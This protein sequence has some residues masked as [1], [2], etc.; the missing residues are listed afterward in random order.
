LAMGQ[1]MYSTDYDDRLPAAGTWNDTLPNYVRNDRTF[2]CPMVRK[3]GE[4]GG[5]A[6]N[7]SLSGKKLASYPSPQSIVSIYESANLKANAAGDPK[8][9]GPTNRHGPGRNEGY[10]DGHGKWIKTG[11]S[12][13]GMP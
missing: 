7:S 5:Y 3:K 8:S 6:M 10:L 13:S 4:R 11:D 2:D 9:E 12:T 1:I